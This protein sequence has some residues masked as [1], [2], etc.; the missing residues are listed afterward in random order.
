MVQA[1]VWPI[2]SPSNTAHAELV[3]RRNFIIAGCVYYACYKFYT[4]SVFNTIFDWVEEEAQQMTRKERE[5]LEE[6]MVEPLFIPLPFT[7]KMVDSPPYKNSDPEWQA[8][9]KFNKNKELLK[10]VRGKRAKSGQTRRKNSIL[11]KN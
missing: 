2:L 4:A 6:D 3:T 1:D 8:F 9:I 11:T 7:M 5:E 10:S